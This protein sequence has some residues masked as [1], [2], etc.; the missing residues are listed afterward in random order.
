MTATSHQNQALTQQAESL[1]L[2]TK[3]HLPLSVG[4]PGSAIAP[5]NSET[6]R[7][8]AIKATG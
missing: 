4:R 5:D 6:L 8:I 1:P 7:Q 2:L 3:E